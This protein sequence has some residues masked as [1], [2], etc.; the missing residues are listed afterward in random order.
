M[1]KYNK[2][3]K[4]SNNYQVNLLIFRFTIELQRLAS[5]GHAHDYQLANFQV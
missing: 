2:Q 1:N 3:I 5:L 4:Y